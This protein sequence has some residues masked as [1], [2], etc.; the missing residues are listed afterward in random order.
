MVDITEHKQM[1]VA[2]RNALR[3]I[4]KN[5]E[6]FAI[7]GDHIRNP[8]TAIV[9]LTCM[10]EDDI[11]DKVLLQVREI[12]R[13]IT[14]IDTGWIES[15]KVRNILKKYYAI[16]AEDIMEAEAGS[17]WAPGATPVIK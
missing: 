3:Q 7:L 1:E 13:I 2:Q 15:E 17:G 6:Q 14:R 12:D 5:I 16:G 9:G 10:I 4:E 8:L 11:S